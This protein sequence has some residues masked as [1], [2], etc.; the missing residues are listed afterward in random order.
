MEEE[1]A[2]ASTSP[3][4]EENLYRDSGYA[5]LNG[6]DVKPLRRLVGRRVSEA[7]RDGR[8]AIGTA[9]GRQRPRGLADQRRRAGPAG[10]ED[11]EG[12]RPPPDRRGDRRNPAAG[13]RRDAIPGPGGGGPLAKG[14]PAPRSV[15]R[16]AVPP[17][18]PPKYAT[19]HKIPRRSGAALPAR[20]VTPRRG[21]T[22]PVDTRPLRRSRPFPEEYPWTFFSRPS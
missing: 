5:S 20:E 9:G 4:L 14:V 17:A 12:S 18:P 11:A 6:I 8:W 2:R 19:D 1:T 3:T 16:T 15:P 13:P 7:R 10:R 22:A 21:A